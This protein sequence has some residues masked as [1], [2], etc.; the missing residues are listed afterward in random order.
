MNQLELGLYE[1]RKFQEFGGLAKNIL[2]LK[3][4]L[5]TALHGWANQLDPCPCGCR[6][7]P[8]A[9]E[10]LAK[11]G[12]HG[13]LIPIDGNMGPEEQYMS[14]LRHIHPWEMALLM[15][16]RPNKNWGS[17][18]KLAIS[19]IGQIASPLQSGWILAQYLF[20]TNDLGPNRPQTPEEVL[21]NMMCALMQDRDQIFP[22]LAQQGLSNDFLNT[23]SFLMNMSQSRVIPAT[24]DLRPDPSLEQNAVEAAT[25]VP[26][27]TPLPVVPFTSTVVQSKVGLSQVLEKYCLQNLVKENEVVPAT[28]L[29]SQESQHT[30]VDAE[31]DEWLEVQQKLL[32]YHEK[33]SEQDV[34]AWHRTGGIPGFANTLATEEP[35]PKRPKTAET[36]AAKASDEEE[37]SEV[38]RGSERLGYHSGQPEALSN[39]EEAPRDFGAGSNDGTSDGRGNAAGRKGSALGIQKTDGAIEPVWIV[40]NPLEAPICL[41]ASPGTVVKDLVAAEQDLHQHPSTL[42]AINR[43]GHLVKPHDTIQVGQTIHL[44][45]QGMGTEGSN[46]FGPPRCFEHSQPITRIQL[47][48]QQMG[49]MTQ[50]E[51]DFHLH[52]L[53]LKCELSWKP[54]FPKVKGDPKQ[55]FED[56]L[57]HWFE[58]I[59]DSLGIS[60]VLIT[61]F[62]HQYHW[63]PVALSA[64]AS[65][66]IYTTNQGAQLLGSLLPELS[67]SWEMHTVVLPT[68]FRADCGFQAVGWLTRFLTGT[69]TRQVSI[70]IAEQWRQDFAAYLAEHNHW[71]DLV[72]PK[73]INVG[74]MIQSESVDQQLKALLKQH[75]VPS[76]ASQQRANSVLEHLGRH[77]VAATLRAQKPWKDL[78]ARANLHTPKIQLVMGDEL[79]QVIK[80]RVDQGLPFGQKRQKKANNRSG[81]PISLQPEDLEIPFGIF[82]E[83]IDTSLSQIAMGSLGP[84]AQGVIVC[85]LKEATPFL[86]LPKPVSKHGL[87]LLILEHGAEAVQD[88][89][90]MTRFP[91]TCVRTGE[92]LLASARLVQLGSNLVVRNEPQTKYQIEEEVTEVIR[93]LVYRDEITT[94]WADFTVNP[95][96]QLLQWISP[97]TPQDPS[98]PHVIDVWDRQ[99][100]TAKMDRV[101]QSEAFMFIVTFRVVHV[102]LKTLLSESGKHGAYLEP[103]TPDGRAPST[104][105][106]VLWLPH[107]DKQHAQSA[108]Q[109]SEQ[110]ACIVR[111]GNRFGIRSTCQEAQALHKMHKPDTPFLDAAHTLHFTAG[112]FPYGT[113]KQALVKVFALW[114]WNA[115][116]LQ[117]KARSLD[118][119][120]VI[121]GIQA[122]TK[123]KF[124]IYQMKHGDVLITEIPPRKQSEPQQAHGIVASTKTLTALKEGAVKSAQPQ[125]PWDNQDPW[126]NWQP[127]KSIRSAPA[128]PIKLDRTQLDTLETAIESKVRANLAKVQTDDEP[129]ESAAQERIT[130]LEDRLNKVEQVMQQNAVSQQQQH[131]ALDKKVDH[132]RHH[133]DQ[134]HQKFNHVL[135]QR[136]S[137]Q[138][139]QIERLL[140]KKPRAE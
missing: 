96:K 85:N 63:I 64:D 38:Y 50:D 88:I 134:S 86:K 109:T 8:L 129:M 26:D 44:Q 110:W 58:H 45:T 127:S 56:G 94:P 22:G 52:R 103:R 4:A 105:W 42:Q 37:P 116:P 67:K 112:P 11:K 102:D 30:N 123:P 84:E 115:R 17:S 97:L 75:G 99:W 118:G 61:A 34:A 60:K 46:S 104:H 21:W 81:Q 87:A 55:A 125:D 36:S 135:D 23:R 15:G 79:A 76:H 53:A 9:F 68:V 62:L 1:F 119:S 57:T 71:F 19:G 95:V 28:A 120:G 12:L 54:S 51:M 80:S 137:E 59:T 3:K 29:E 117:P 7:H 2:N 93:V 20:A 48:R 131:E 107:T 43:L 18:L 49:W 77:T 24:R 10:R 39:A 14:K 126:Q 90:D 133:M 140:A 136:F 92:P 33:H 69:G 72:S 98:V 13:V 108:V 111:S 25:T 83:G 132:L 73:D 40:T 130:V 89:G 74:G 113:T 138:L 128:A 32:E 35:S 91:A 31:F 27:A 114:E 5:P 78:K 100:V 65:K 70:E 16:L 101:K 121:W 41:K 122:S 82:R 66:R 139:G 124:A 6:L 106:R 47:L